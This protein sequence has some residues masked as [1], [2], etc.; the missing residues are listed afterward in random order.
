MR[1]LLLRGA[2]LWWNSTWRP[3]RPQDCA[4]LPSR[5]AVCSRAR[6][7]GRWGGCAWRCGCGVWSA[8]QG[9]GCCQQ[10][11]L[12]GGHSW[13]VLLNCQG[14][15][16]QQQSSQACARCL[17]AG[18]GGGAAAGGLWRGRGGAAGDG[19]GDSGPQAVAR[20]GNR[21]TTSSV[22]R[23]LHLLLRI[24]RPFAGTSANLLAGGG[25]RRRQLLPGAGSACTGSANEFACCPLPHRELGRLPGRPRAGSL[26][27]SGSPTIWS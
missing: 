10:Y 22:N 12:R 26:G 11:Q 23:P 14:G 24:A 4:P 15:G 17:S 8:R 21:S 27:T 13:V 3:A 9:E 20:P 25:W 7:G 2:C 16:R 1:R 6:A 5:Q 19:G 18:S